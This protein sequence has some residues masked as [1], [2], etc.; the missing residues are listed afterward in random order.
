MVLI[1]KYQNSGIIARQDNTY[2]SKPIM[3]ERIKRTYI[4]PQQAQFIQD[5]RTKWQQIR[6]RAR[7]DREYDRYMEAKKTEEGLR[8]LEGFL[9]FTDYAGL[10]TGVGSIISKGIPMI[11]RQAAKQLAKRS[12]TN[13][14]REVNKVLSTNIKDNAVINAYR[15]NPRIVDTGTLNEYSKYLS[16]IFPDSQLQDVYFHGGPKGIIKFNRPNSGARNKA[17]NSITKDHGIYF[18][19]T[20]ELSKYY[21][22][23]KGQVYRVKINSP[24]TMRYDNPHMIFDKVKG[25]QDYRFSADAVTNDWYNRLGLDRY[26]SIVKEK[27]ANATSKGQITVFNPDDIRILGSSED[28]QGFKQWKQNPVT[29]EHT[30][31]RIPNTPA[32]YDRTL[33]NAAKAYTGPAVIGGMLAA[34]VIGLLSMD[35]NKKKEVKKKKEKNDIQ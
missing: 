4:P 11:S 17:I 34:P 13:R 12:M 7:A 33:K 6:D 28:L 26:N 27:S 19:D 21:A 16:S 14:V 31:S 5:N 35:R 32:Q 2:V 25:S 1:P 20:E 18:A 22:G 8:A 9:T 15:S 10:A 23:N 24:N 30:Y 3:P 29:V